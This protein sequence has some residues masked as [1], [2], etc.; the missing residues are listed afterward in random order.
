MD[1][2]LAESDGLDE[3]DGED[4][5]DGDCDASEDVLFDGEPVGDEDSAVPAVVI[6]PGVAVGLTLTNAGVSHVDGV[7]D[8]VVVP[9]VE[10]T[11]GSVGFTIARICVS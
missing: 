11:G 5:S 8:P 2:G 4:D 9:L 7:G 3:S 1:V 10:V 6:A